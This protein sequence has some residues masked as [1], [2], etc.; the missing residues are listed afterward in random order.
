M[1]FVASS[2]DPGTKA[3]DSCETMLAAIG[4]V[5][6]CSQAIVFRYDMSMTYKND[7]FGLKMFNVS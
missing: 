1:L 2:H 4:S 7:S 6:W 3:M 5:L